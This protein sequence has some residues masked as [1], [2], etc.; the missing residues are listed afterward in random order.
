M[1]RFFTW[2]GVFF[3]LAGAPAKWLKVPLSR[4]IS[5]LNFRP[6]ASIA[7]PGFV[8]LFTYGTLACLIAL[9]VA[10]LANRRFAIVRF[11]LGAALV[12][13]GA[14]IFLN[15]AFGR[16]EPLRTLLIEHNQYRRI[17]AFTNTELPL[18]RGVEPTIDPSIDIS[19]L[20]DRANAAFYF[21]GLGWTLLLLGGGAVLIGATA[22]L[23][24][25]PPR[26]NENRNAPAA[27]RVA[28]APLALPIGTTLQ[29]ATIYLLLFTIWAA[30]LLAL[31]I[32]LVATAVGCGLIVGLIRRA[33]PGRILR[34][35]LQV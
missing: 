34:S 11:W 24:L 35:W 33:T 10:A 16:A 12:G 13:I 3:V 28:P 30:Q 5:G 7:H 2:V 8:H 14:F 4:W 6:G 27:D 32:T 17:G 15:L 20:W 19:T 9:A 25:R 22:D 29:I 21:L 18:N 1:S 26:G 31:S 23:A